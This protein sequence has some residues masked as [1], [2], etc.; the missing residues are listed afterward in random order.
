[1]DFLAGFRQ[2]IGSKY[3]PSQELASKLLDVRAELKD[4]AFIANPNKVVE[5]AD[6]EEDDDDFDDEDEDNDAE[7]AGL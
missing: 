4:C 6:D 1:M 7:K 2:G 3:G 5:D